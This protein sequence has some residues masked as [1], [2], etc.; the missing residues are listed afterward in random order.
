[1]DY[2]T[3][4]NRDEYVDVSV[5]SLQRWLLSTDGLT[6]PEH[7]FLTVYTRYPESLID[8]YLNS[9]VLPQRTSKNNRAYIVILSSITKPVPAVYIDS[10][11][12][13]PV[14]LK[15]GPA[16]QASY[17]NISASSYD[18]ASVAGYDGIIVS[19]LLNA[20]GVK[21]KT[22]GLTNNLTPQA[23][24]AGSGSGSEASNTY[25]E[26]SV[27]REG[28]YP[29]WETP[30]LLEPDSLPMVNRIMS[31]DNVGDR[32][33]TNIAQPLCDTDNAINPGG[34]VSA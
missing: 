2:L 7:N 18:D 24:T 13:H 5:R 6:T 31:L 25:G 3:N 15:D 28:T 12:R 26:F 20:L 17:I 11:A 1:M 8:G 23:T 10:T 27:L 16:V 29:R 32:V 21:G 9:I 14:W 19:H 30:R 4:P 22:T 34:I 33:I